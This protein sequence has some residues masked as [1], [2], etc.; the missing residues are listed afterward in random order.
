M[1]KFGYFFIKIIIAMELERDLE[2]IL[3]DLEYEEK[4]NT[5]YLKD[6]KFREKKQLIEYKPIDYNILN[7]ITLCMNI[8]FY[9][10]VRSN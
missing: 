4:N 9:S 7:Y 5:R 6:K 2:L 1:L 8:Y 3:L 10:I